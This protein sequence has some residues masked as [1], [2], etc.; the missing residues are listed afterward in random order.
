MLHF[1]TTNYN[2]MYDTCYVTDDILVSLV[3]M[4]G[5][6]FLAYINDNKPTVISAY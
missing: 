2:R 1:F 4:L 3:P 5:G 6:T